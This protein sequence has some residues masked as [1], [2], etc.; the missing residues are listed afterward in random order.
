MKMCI[1]TL[2]FSPYLQI[3]EQEDFLSQISGSQ[4]N[5]FQKVPTIHILSWLFQKGSNS[6]YVVNPAEV[7]SVQFV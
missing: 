6:F 2:L 3:T 7:F 5:R 1:K 4:Q